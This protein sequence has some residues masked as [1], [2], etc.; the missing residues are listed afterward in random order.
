M[1]A[2]NEKINTLL[3]ERI[4]AGDFPSAVY[5]VAERGR[6]KLSGALGQ[7][8]REPEPHAATLET[9]YDLAS[10]TKPLITSLLCA[11][12][13]ERGELQLDETIAHYL[14]AF[15]RPEKRT[16]TVRQLLTHSSGFPAWRPLYVALPEK[17]ER[18]LE[19]IAAQ[20]LEYIPGTRVVYSDLG[21]TALGFLLEKIFNDS[22]LSIAQQEIFNPLKL[23]RTFFNPPQSLRNEIAANE[24]GNP[25]E[26][27]LYEALSEETRLSLSLHDD[28]RVWRKELIWGTVDDGNAN[29]LGGV[30]GHAGVFSTAHE[31]LR[32]A[33]QFLAQQTELLAPETCELFRTNMT[34]QLEEARSLG[35]QLAATPRSTAGTS[36]PPD[37]FGHPGFTGTSC[38][39]DPNNERTYIL[40]TNRTHKRPYPFVNIN[41]TRRLF[42]TLAAA[43]L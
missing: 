17:P 39:N 43:A 40:L 27:A 8:V 42:H 10:L 22:L 9:I 28:P 34:P 38:W 32:L 6:V 23:H 4:A 19:F 37:S 41:N 33:Q 2:H 30:A 15:E 3:T 21:F 11:Q 35:W 5:L 13:I 1:E 24:A 25:V 14:P 16:M 36:L 7:A 20:P 12:Q 18:A 31:T 29:F 26:R